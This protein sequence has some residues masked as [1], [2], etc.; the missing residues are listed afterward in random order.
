M[1]EITVG[2][3]W[4]YNLLAND[5][6]GLGAIPIGGVFRGAAGDGTATPYIVMQYM[7]GHDVIGSG[8]HRIMADMPFHVYAIGPASSYANV[9][10]AANRLDTLL[11]GASGTTS[12]GTVIAC[13]RQ[14]PISIEE[15]VNGVLWTR[16]GGVY[17]IWAQT[18]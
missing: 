5:P 4:L 1:N 14:S 7:G 6:T 15:N 17:R 13:V 3:E 2:Y 9:K 12:G 8:G 11:Q 16:F 18:L 10:L